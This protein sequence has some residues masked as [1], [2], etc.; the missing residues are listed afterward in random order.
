M[1]RTILV[2]V[3][4]VT[5]LTV[6]GFR[7]TDWFKHETPYA[8][9]EFPEKPA[10][11]VQTVKAAAGDMA[12]E[13]AMYKGIREKDDNLVYG[14]FSFVYPD[15][16]FT[17]DNEQLLPKFFRNSIDS[18]VNRVKG[19]LLTEKEILMDGYPGRE[20]R[21]DYGGGMAILHITVYLVWNR[22]MM[23][24]TIAP[25]DKDNNPSAVRF[26]SSLKIRK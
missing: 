24:Q 19:K 6:S 13:T 21:V 7:V 25:S 18:A 5:L 8:T 22:V 3:L 23:I 1:I 16:L 4:S 20:V 17:S 15:S 26:H 14:F 12:V 10:T 11:T 9:I 2:V